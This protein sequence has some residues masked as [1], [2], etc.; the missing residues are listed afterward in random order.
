M[1][2]HF[3]ENP[4]TGLADDRWHQGCLHCDPSFTL[5]LAKRPRSDYNNKILIVYSQTSVYICMYIYIYIY[6][7]IQYIYTSVIE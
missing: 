3:L 5:I 1:R 4:Q 2:I 6:I 7:Y